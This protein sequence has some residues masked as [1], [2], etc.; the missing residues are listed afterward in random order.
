MLKAGN[1]GVEQALAQRHTLGPQNEAVP[2]VLRKES[3]QAVKLL[4]Q[5][6]PGLSIAA[7]AP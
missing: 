5:A 4:V 3:T 2:H 6:V 7:I 1:I